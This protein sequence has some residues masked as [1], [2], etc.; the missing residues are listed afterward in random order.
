MTQISKVWSKRL[1]L[2]AYKEWKVSW[3]KKI[4]IDA[5]RKWSFHI[6]ERINKNTYKLNLPSEYDVNVVFNVS[7]LFLF[8]VGDDL[9]M[10]PFELRGNDTIQ[11]TLR[12]PLEV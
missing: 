8:D 10:N 12:D 9:R 1:V 11:A 7:Y 2:G 4:K 3:T 5:L 6:I